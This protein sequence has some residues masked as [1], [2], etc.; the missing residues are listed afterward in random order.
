[1]RPAIFVTFL[2]A[3][4]YTTYINCVELKFIH[5]VADLGEGPEEPELP[6]F[7]DKRHSFNASPRLNLFGCTHTKKGPPLSS[8]SGSST[9]LDMYTN[10]E[11]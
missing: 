2:F 9:D 4:H 1:M 7:F 11:N 6:P 8:R 3:L 10:Y 5:T